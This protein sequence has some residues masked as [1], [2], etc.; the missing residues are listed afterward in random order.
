MTGLARVVARDVVRVLARRF[1]AIVAGRAIGG[2]AGM[3][4]RRRSPSCGF[5]TVF[6]YIAC[7]QMGC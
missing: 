1:R 4:K 6:A 2:D 3:A 5:V 7:G